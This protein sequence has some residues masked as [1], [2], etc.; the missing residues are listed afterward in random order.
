M[1]DIFQKVLAVS[2]VILAGASIMY[3]MT[4]N[5]NGFPDLK[6]SDMLRGK[7]LLRWLMFN[8]TENGE[9]FFGSLNGL[10]RTRISF[11]GSSCYVSGS[12]RWLLYVQA[13]SVG[14]LFQ[15]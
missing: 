2:L 13:F 10:P 5:E 15:Q 14:E 7:A 1:F 6:Q 11:H 12:Y 3:G 8:R 9:S 4:L